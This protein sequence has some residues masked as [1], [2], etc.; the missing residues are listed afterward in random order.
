MLLD[1][2]TKSETF[3]QLAYQHQTTI[4]SEPRPLEIDLQRGVEGKL[5]GLIL[6]LTHWVCTPKRLD[7][8][9]ARM[10]QGFQRHHNLSRSVSNRKCG[11]RE[12][13]LEVNN[14]PCP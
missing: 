10:N 4:G 13:L 5:K 1:E 8:A 14:W 11:F 6:Y 12:F 7:H 9:E 2:F 3:V